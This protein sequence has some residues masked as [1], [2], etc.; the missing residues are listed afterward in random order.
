MIFTTTDGYELVKSSNGLWFCPGDPEGDCWPSGPDG[1][2][3]ET[4]SDGSLKEPMWGSYI[5]DSGEK[6]IVG[7]VSNVVQRFIHGE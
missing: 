7:E 5:D 6:H 2:P 4:Y 1:M 3:W